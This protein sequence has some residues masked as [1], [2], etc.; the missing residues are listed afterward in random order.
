MEYW[1][2]LIQKEGDRSWLSLKKPSLE[3][4]EGRYRVVAHSN[5]PN[6][7]VE[8]RITH[9]STEEVPPRRRSQKRSRRTNAQGLMVVIPFT[10]FKPGIWDLRC[11]GDIMSDFLGNTWQQ[12]MKFQVLPKAAETSTDGDSAGQE[13]SVVSD[14]NSAAEMPETSLPSTEAESQRW[15]AASMPVSD[16]MEHS[17]QMVD[18][19]LHEVVDPLWQAFEP[20]PAAPQQRLFTLDSE[21]P[22]DELPFQS[23]IDSPDSFAT[24]ITQPQVEA[25]P[26]TFLRLI[27]DQENFVARRG[28]PIIFSGEVEVLDT[29]SSQNS[30]QGGTLRVE[31]RDPQN[32]KILVD[33]EQPL[34]E[35]VSSFAFRCNLELPEECKTRLILGEVTL[36]DQT[37]TVLATQSFTVTADLEDLLGAIAND[38]EAENLLNPPLGSLLA[39][40]PPLD[41]SFLDLVQQPK[42]NQSLRLEPLPNQPLPPQITRSDP[43]KEAALKAPELPAIASDTDATDSEGKTSVT[44]APPPLGSLPPKIY[45]PDPANPVNKTL[46]LP[47]IS[48]SAPVT[49]VQEAIIDS[50]SSSELEPPTVENTAQEQAASDVEQ[51][52]DNLLNN[53]ADSWQRSEIPS[54]EDDREDA[55]TTANE[56]V[57]VEEPSDTPESDKPAED[58]DSPASTVDTAFATLKLKDRFL[59]RLNDLANDEELAQLLQP[60]EELPATEPELIE[61]LSAPDVAQEDSEDTGV[62]DGTETAAIQLSSETDSE[63]PPESMSPD[64][65]LVAQLLDQQPPLPEFDEEDA[66]ISSDAPSNSEVAA[67]NPLTITQ[68]PTN[69]FWTANSDGNWADQEI[70]V[71]DDPFE[72]PL[73]RSDRISPFPSHYPQQQ[74]SALDEEPV[75]APELVLPEGELIA[76]QL[77]LLRVKLNSEL[78]R[79]YV[80]LWVHDR[81]TRSLLD[82]PRWL[83]DF[84]P[85]AFGVLET[86]TQLTVPFGSMSIRFEAV[87]VDTYT[88]RESHKVTLDRI[89]IPPDLPNW[90]LDEF[91]D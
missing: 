79:I 89:V 76:G 63:A 3:I 55:D 8:I 6:T 53:L 70:V 49:E 50:S 86:M 28:E 68:N 19:I 12:A 35:Q 25:T 77:L 30:V 39:E 48:G 26:E 65:E 57:A 54:A 75:P 81:Q 69:A 37:Q 18:E 91:G 32:S 52:V 4:L 13:R 56:D 44:P 7:D 46:K 58:S 82:G 66:A 34:P 80:K 84:S 1:E 59:S 51:L 45:R 88:Q 29:S 64:W 42:D 72:E 11:S 90:S 85:N 60:E 74:A 5:R 67:E 61:S 83:V 33:V 23:A 21:P 71:D 16:L 78:S 40:T 2:F 9:D 15:K 62:V 87:T 27:L 20:I 31:M 14:T 17:L 47:L 24:D 22:R 38:R 41:S 43:A 73:G 10:Y 36:I